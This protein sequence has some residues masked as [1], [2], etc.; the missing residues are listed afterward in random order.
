MA[1]NPGQYL[2][3]AGPRMQPA[4]DLLARI[5]QETP[6]TVIDL[7]CGPG[8]ITPLL[9][10]RW[11][12]ASILGLDNSD[13]MLA[14][15]R[16]AMPDETFEFADITEW[17]PATRYD[18]V[19]SNAALQWVPDH[20]TLFPRLLGYV[21]PGGTLAIQIPR[22]DD[23]PS[24][25][26][27]DDVIE[28]G[29]WRDLLAPIRDANPTQKPAW[30]RNLLA[31]QAKDLDIWETEYLQVL[32]GDNPVA[33][34]TR[35]SQLTRYLGKMDE[36]WRSE[37]ESRYRALVAKAYPPESDGRTLF[38]FRRLFIVASA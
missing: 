19:F 9:R 7:G 25:R 6:G 24:H 4:I 17:T 26:L 37:F 31:G 23:A 33:E 22:N 34:Y 8:N 1:W 16:T 32:D 20:D 15:A 12:D 36:P 35:G 2:A 21:A 28:D 3:F 14:R 11:P 27:I 13:T 29:P 18:V 38:A 5:P 10:R 30:Y